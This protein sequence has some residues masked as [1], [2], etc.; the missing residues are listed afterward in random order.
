MPKNRSG[1]DDTLA[2]DEQ[3]HAKRLGSDIGR[4]HAKP[5]NTAKKKAEGD[6]AKDAL[7]A[8]DKLTKGRPRT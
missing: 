3:A 8:G 5:G 4:Y 1:H 2:A 7:T 6:V